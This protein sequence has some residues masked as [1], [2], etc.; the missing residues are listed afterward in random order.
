MIEASAFTAANLKSL[1]AQSPYAISYSGS[2]F[3]E[4]DFRDLCW[5]FSKT[6]GAINRYMKM[7]K[8]PLSDINRLVNDLSTTDAW[9]MQS[10]AAF[11]CKLLG[12]K[13]LIS[14]I[15]SALKDLGNT[16]TDEISLLIKHM[17]NV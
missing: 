12:P 5:G 1:W 15:N 8:L 4:T 16:A 17:V 9:N 10:L 2:M 7:M 14:F 11:E 3:E 13:A 6:Y